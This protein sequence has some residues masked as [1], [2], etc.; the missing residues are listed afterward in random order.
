MISFNKDER[1]ICAKSLEKVLYHISGLNKSEANWTKGVDTI[2]REY[3]KH[4][5]GCVDCTITYA[6]FLNSERKKGESTRDV[7]KEYLN[8]FKSTN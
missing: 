1:E 2:K 6:K 3:Q 7:D 8:C 5:P 4:I